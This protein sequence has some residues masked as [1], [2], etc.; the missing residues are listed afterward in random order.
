M[1]AAHG[2]MARDGKPKLVQIRAPHFTAGAE[3]VDGKVV[4]AAPIIA[5]LHGWE[6]SRA[7]SYMSRKG[8]TFKEI[9]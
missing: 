1:I 6:W 8:W 2:S 9:S 4:R 3:I 5:Y 7:S